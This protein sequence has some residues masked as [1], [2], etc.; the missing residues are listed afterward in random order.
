MHDIVQCSHIPLAFPGQ[1]AG[2]AVPN[3][4]LLFLI[5][6]G[7]LLLRQSLHDPLLVLNIETAQPNGCIH[8]AAAVAIWLLAGGKELPGWTDVDTSKITRKIRWFSYKPF[9]VLI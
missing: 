4:F 7:W 9:L 8:V 5:R 6:N 1:C 2:V 3:I